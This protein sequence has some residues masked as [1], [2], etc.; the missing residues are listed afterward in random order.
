METK[1]FNPY[2]GFILFIHLLLM[3][4]KVEWKKG[5]NMDFFVCLF[6]RFLGLINVFHA[7]WRGYFEGMTII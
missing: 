1:H 2:I 4:S 3:E 5:D 6:L 7:I